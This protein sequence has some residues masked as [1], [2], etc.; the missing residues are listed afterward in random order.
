MSL[1]RK[2]P[3]SVNI[4]VPDISQQFQEASNRN[5]IAEVLRELFQE[6]KIYLITDLSKDEIKLCTRIYML[7]EMKDLDAWKKGLKFF[8][9]L[10]LSKDRKSRKELLEAMKGQI[11]RTAF[12][13]KINPFQRR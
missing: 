7:A 12:M 2:E 5:E 3:Q 10:M 6:G 8:V 4:N 9:T 11:G 13:D 1:F